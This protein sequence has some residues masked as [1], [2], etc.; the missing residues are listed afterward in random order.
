MFKV[1]LDNFYFFKFS[2]D[3]FLRY[4]LDS[5]SILYDGIEGIR[6]NIKIQLSRKANASHHAPAR[7]KMRRGTT[8]R[9]GAPAH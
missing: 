9:Q 5:F 8:A 6:G 1:K 3:P 2:N 7:S 4:D